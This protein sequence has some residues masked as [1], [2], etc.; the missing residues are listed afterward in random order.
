MQE[1][2]IFLYSYNFVLNTVSVGAGILFGISF[3]IVSKSLTYKQL[4]FYL[5]ISGAGIMIVLSNS[6][7]TILTLAPFPA[8]AITSLSFMLPAS[9]LILIGLD[10]TIYHVGRDKSIR[11]FLSNYQ[12]QFELFKALGSAEAFKVVERKVELASKR[13]VDELETETLFKPTL[14]SEETKR[15]VKEVITEMKESRRTRN[16]NAN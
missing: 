14:E 7:S 3:F 1:D 11:K 13:I 15:Y 16:N 5:I 4:K 8:W 12:D 2:P 9:F 6:L 10:I